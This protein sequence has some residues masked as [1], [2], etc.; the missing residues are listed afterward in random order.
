MSDAPRFAR[1]LNDPDVNKFTTR[2]SISMKEE[3]KWIHGLRKD[4]S[5]HHFAI[6]TKDGIHIGS[7]GLREK[8]LRDKNMV[9][10]IFIGDK[11]YWSK[12]YGTDVMI[13]VL[14]FGFGKLK[15]HRIEADVFEY[16][17]RS[18]AMCRKLGFKIEGVKRERIFYK[19]RWHNL[20]QLGLLDHERKK[21]QRFA[22]KR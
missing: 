18:L 3:K 7:V 8:N 14:N 22:K 20:I 5:A 10:G 2:K 9:A 16:N 11:K 4:K 1:W 21:H 15:L 12:G 13:S 17:P 6:D 19:G